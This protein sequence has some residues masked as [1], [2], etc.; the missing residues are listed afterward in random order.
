M[1]WID[2]LNGKNGETV[3]LDEFQYRLYEWPVSNEIKVRQLEIELMRVIER[4]KTSSDEQST[5]LDI[6]YIAVDMSGSDVSVRVG[7]K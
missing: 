6:D 1:G 7:L 4:Y 3:I 2:K 5:G